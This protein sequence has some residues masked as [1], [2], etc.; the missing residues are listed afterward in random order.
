MQFLMPITSE[1][2]TCSYLGFIDLVHCPAK[3]KSGSVSKTSCKKQWAGKG[4]PA[5][6]PSVTNFLNHGWLHLFLHPIASSNLKKTVSQAIQLPYSHLKGSLWSS[7]SQI[8]SPLKMP[9]LYLRKNI[10]SQQVLSKLLG[11]EAISTLIHL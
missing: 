3:E 7:A 1:L 5:S 4:S 11:S 6:A 10:Y 9:P 8:L 2:C